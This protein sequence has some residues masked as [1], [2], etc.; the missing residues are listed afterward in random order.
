MSH[1][2]RRALAETAA[3]LSGGGSYKQHGTGKKTT[4]TSKKPAKSGGTKKRG[5]GYGHGH[6]QKGGNCGPYEFTH[7]QANILLVVSDMNSDL[8]G[9]N[10]K[11]ME[12][13]MISLE[14]E[15]E[16]RMV[17]ISITDNEKAALSSIVFSQQNKNL[18]SIVQ[19]IKKTN[20]TINA[21]Q[22]SMM[23]QLEIRLNRYNLME[24]LKQKYLTKL[25]KELDGLKSQLNTCPSP[26][27]PSSTTPTTQGGKKTHFLKKD[28]KN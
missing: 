20:A 10:L 13:I 7:K 4:A 14:Q 24:G 18:A 23:N 25:Q 21:D 8:T 6:K 2:G 11:V 15:G 3:T 27:S 19:E 22:K 5:G 1:S 17:K 26:P 28:K 9:L 16:N 12:A